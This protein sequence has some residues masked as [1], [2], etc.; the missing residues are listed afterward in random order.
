[1]NAITFISPLHRSHCSQ[2][3][4]FVAARFVVHMPQ[5]RPL[6]TGGVKRGHGSF[7]CPVSR[8]AHAIL[9][10]CPNPAVT[11][12]S[13]CSRRSISPSKFL[14]VGSVHAP[15]IPGGSMARGY[16]HQ[17]TAKRGRAAIARRQGDRLHA[18]PLG[19]TLP[20]RRRRASSDRQQCGRVPPIMTTGIGL[21]TSITRHPPCHRRVVE[22]H[23]AVAG[24][25]DE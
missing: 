9:V 3:M 23:V 10:P 24:G 8:S 25:K 19:G 14:L 15:R 20:P 22:P 16:I 11:G 5:V 2:T 6:A 12:P 18:Q 17:A 13:L 4:S 7:A 21:F 1:M